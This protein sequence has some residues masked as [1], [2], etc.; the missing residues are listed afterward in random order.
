MYHE[1]LRATGKR[2]FV[3]QNYKEI[4]FHTHPLVDLS[5]FLFVPDQVKSATDANKQETVHHMEVV[6]CLVDSYKFCMKKEVDYAEQQNHTIQ[7]AE[8]PDKI[9][10]VFHINK[11]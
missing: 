10:K 8:D 2:L 9:F 5:L 6:Y 3:Y 1:N 7:H 11:V 4:W